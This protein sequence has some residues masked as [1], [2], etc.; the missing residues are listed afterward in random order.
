MGKNGNWKEENY[1]IKI[2]D[3]FTH[4]EGTEYVVDVYDANGEE[5]AYFKFNHWLNHPHH[6]E[7]IHV[8]EAEVMKEHRRKGIATAVYD[9]IEETL[10]IKI[11][12]EPD[13][14]TDLAK[15]F[16]KNRK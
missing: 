16:W 6:G 2:S 8:M 14:Q 1:V 13:Q 15:V 10:G 12:H 9:L 5:C 11:H 7:I 4:R 3:G